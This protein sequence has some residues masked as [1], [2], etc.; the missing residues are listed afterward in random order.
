MTSERWKASQREDA[1]DYPEKSPLCR[2]PP[3]R[4]VAVDGGTTLSFVASPFVAPFMPGVAEWIISKF[5]NEI[6]HP[7]IDRQ[8]PKLGTSK[9]MCH[10]LMTIT[11]S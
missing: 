9:R 1:G 10:L 8:T 6:S 2:R 4:W 5:T 7:P 11:G 3:T